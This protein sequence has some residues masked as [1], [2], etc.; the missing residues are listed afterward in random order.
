MPK[1][2]S[3]A[4]NHSFHFS[5]SARVGYL[6]DLN[7]HLRSLQTQTQGKATAAAASGGLRVLTAE[8]F[9]VLP[10]A[11]SAAGPEPSPAISTGGYHQTGAAAAVGEPS[12]VS[13]PARHLPV[14]PQLP[15]PSSSD[16]APIAQRPSRGDDSQPYFQQQQQYHQQQRLSRPAQQEELDG[17]CLDDSLLWQQ[18]RGDDYSSHQPILPEAEP[19]AS[20]RKQQPPPRQAYAVPVGAQ[21]PQLAAVSRGSCA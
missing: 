12:T 8:D 9:L 14:I 16:Q 3:I 19:S 15:L 13:P 20:A 7:A 1:P 10:A 11:K 6:P 4:C 2:T 18:Q 5:C 17:R 21:L